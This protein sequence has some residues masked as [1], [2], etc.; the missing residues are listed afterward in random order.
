[1]VTTHGPVRGKIVDSSF[2]RYL[3]Y[4]GIP[5]AENPTSDLRFKVCFI[6]LNIERKKPILNIAMHRFRILQ[7][8]QY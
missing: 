7:F 2:G 3:S 5:Y 6:L 4:Q 1:M 8:S